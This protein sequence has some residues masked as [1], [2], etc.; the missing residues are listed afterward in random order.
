MSIE[1]AIEINGTR[2]ELEVEPTETVLDLL[3]ERLELTGTHR[4]C[5]MG[6]CGA[7]T[8]LFDRR[9]VSSC[10]LLAVQANG[11]AVT[12]IEALERDGALSALQDAFLRHGATQ[13][14]YCTPG[15]L[16]TAT[17]LLEANPSPSRAD[18]VEALKG[19]LCRCTGYKK[20]IEAV[21]SVA[22]RRPADPRRS[23]EP[24]SPN[25]PGI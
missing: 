13:C 9:P 22:A 15:F 11:G 8:V 21:E 10:L 18:I 20:I 23:A 19:N 5:C 12:T 2:H 14:G 24:A 17:A 1:V 25:H 6:I 16:M 3:R 7:C 4:D